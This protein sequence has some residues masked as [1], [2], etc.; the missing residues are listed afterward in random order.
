MAATSDQR[1]LADLGAGRT[2]DRASARLRAGGWLRTRDDVRSH[3]RG[4]GRHPRLS[5]G[6]R[7]DERRPCVPPVAHARAK[8]RELLYSGDSI[9]GRE[10]AE[11]G[12]ANRCYPADQLQAET[13]RFA[14]RI[15]NIP[16]DMLMMSKRGLNRAYEVMGIRTALQVG[17]TSR[18]SRPT[19]PAPAS[20]VASREKRGSRRRWTG[21][22]VRSGTIAV[23]R[24]SHRRGQTA[25]TRQRRRR[26]MERD[27][28]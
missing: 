8:A 6:A 17:R 3:V 16:S 9:T 23:Q 22:T 25:T 19:G 27:P 11:I 4:G 18:P 7:V 10:A 20:S 15:A 5:A 12:W 13:E 26:H 28:N 14:E 2:G 1:L 24:L 21:A